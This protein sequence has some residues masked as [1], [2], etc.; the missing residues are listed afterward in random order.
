MKT[1]FVKINGRFVA[2]TGKVVAIDYIRIDEDEYDAIL[3]DEYVDVIT[4][5]SFGCE[6]DDFYTDVVGEKIYHLVK[7]LAI[8]PEFSGRHGNAKKS[9]RAARMNNIVGVHW[10]NNDMKCIGKNRSC[11]RLIAPSAAQQKEFDSYLPF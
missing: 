10:D 7:A 11:R 3:A 9:R 4:G 1:N 5:E 2:P 8:M 6:L